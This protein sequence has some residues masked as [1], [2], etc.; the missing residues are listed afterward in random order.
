M[1]SFVDIAA[2]NQKDIYNF[3]QPNSLFLARQCVIIMINVTLDYK[4]SLKSHRYICSNCQQYIVWVKMILFNLMPK[5][6]R[7]LRKDHVP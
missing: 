2:S 1:I 7:I 3:S 5:V 4:T 6:I